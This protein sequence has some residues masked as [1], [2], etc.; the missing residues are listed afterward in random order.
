MKKN[1]YFLFL[2]SIFLIFTWS[3]ETFNSAQDIKTSKENKGKEEGIPFDEYLAERVWRLAGCYFEN[4]QYVQLDANLTKSRINFF[5]DGK[6]EATTG[7]TNYEGSW[8][9]TRKNSEEFF[10]FQINGKK[11]ADPSNII[12]KPFDASF[13]R[14]LINIDKLT[15][16]EN[17]IKFYSKEG[18]LLLHFVRL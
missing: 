7:I 1:I 18:E 11:L 16:T 6:F 3:C 15:I 8:T 10:T 2:I 13:E 9:K 5:K 14:N 17:E 12:G 4:G